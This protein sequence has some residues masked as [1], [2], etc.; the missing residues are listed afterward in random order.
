[1]Y[2]RLNYSDGSFVLTIP[3]SVSK[4]RT[5][6]L[7]NKEFREAISKEQVWEF[8]ETL[9][10][11]DYEVLE[12][13]EIKLFSKYRNY[14]SVISDFFELDLQSLIYLDRFYFFICTEPVK[15]DSGEWCRGLSYLEQLLGYSY[16]NYQ[17]AQ[18]TGGITTGNSFLDIITTTILNFKVAGLEDKYSIFELTKMNKYASESAEEA[19]KN[20][21]KDNKNRR[22]TSYATQ[23]K[24]EEL[25]HDF[26]KKE[27]DIFTELN[28]LGILPPS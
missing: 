8:G 22:H 9:K 18:D 16:P 13:L 5:L 11:K 28:S 27:E 10:D 2:F 12:K 20:V 26:L 6:E 17:D 15:L 24:Q 4:A 1:M 25:D 7:Y 23:V 21:N 3:P 19:E 14:Y